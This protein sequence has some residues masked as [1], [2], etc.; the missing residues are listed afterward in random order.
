MSNKHDLYLCVRW[1]QPATQL[2][3]LWR[4]RSVTR[5]RTKA[6]CRLLY[7]CA[8]L[9]HTMKENILWLSEFCELVYVHIE[10]LPVFA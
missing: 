5:L 2:I 1:T 7:S 9:K 8:K 6:Y 4:L 10:G 3:E